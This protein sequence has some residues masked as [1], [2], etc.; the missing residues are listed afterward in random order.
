MGT[1]LK[2]LKHGVRNLLTQPVVAVAAIGSLAL[3]IGMNVSIFSVVNAVLLRG[4]SL[5]QPE[6]L[7]EIYSG[8]NRDYPQ[9]TTSYPDFQ[10][11]ERG[12]DALAGLTASSYVRGII[13]SSGRG[14]LVTGEAVSANYFDLLGIP[15]EHGRG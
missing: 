15:L 10:D 5:R 4:Q 8:L 13:A 11:I 9:L 2:D 12:A 1:L 7:V 14:S 3:G 6:Q